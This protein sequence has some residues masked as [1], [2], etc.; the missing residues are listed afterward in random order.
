MNR[1]TGFRGRTIVGGSQ[2]RSCIHEIISGLLYLRGGNRQRVGGF[3]DRCLDELLSQAFV[4]RRRRQLP[5][6]VS[7]MSAET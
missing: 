7:A 6:L 4:D 3:R 5:V 2:F 1:S